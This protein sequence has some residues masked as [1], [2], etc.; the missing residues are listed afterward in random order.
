MAK[1]NNI[2][3]TPTTRN[4]GVEGGGN[5]IITSGSGTWTAAVSD[6]WI[7]LNSTSGSAGYPVAY[8][9]SVNTNAEQRVG[10]VY[11]SGWTHTITQD[12]VGATIS[13]ENNTVEKDRFVG[14]IDVSAANKIVWHANPDVDWIH[15]SPASG[16]G[17]GTVQYMVEPLEDV[18]TRQGTLT[19][20]GNTFTVFQYG[21][22]MK[23][24]S[25]SVTKDYETH[26][27]PITVNA[28]AITQWSVTP[29]N[30]WISVVDAGNGQGGDL[31]T[32]AIAENPSYK[33]RTGTVKIGTET[34][35][36]TQQGRPT[37]ALS[38]SV[39]PTA[40]TASVEG[41]NGL[42]SVTA[43][44][45][46]P[47]TA[48]SGANW[49][50][51][52][53]ATANGAGNGNVV[54]SASPN[55]T[56]S[57][58]TG[59]ITVKPEAASGMA[60]KTHKVTQPAAQSALSMSGYEFVAAGESCSVDVSVAN[61]VQWSISES[62]D[63]ITVN[64]ST[65]RTGPGTVT[66]QA[67]ANNTVYSR[68]GT[69]KIAGK[70]FSV[71]QKARGV[72]LEYDTKIFGTDGGYES[73][74]IH[75]DGNVSWTAV[76]SDPTWI[77]IFQGDS[78]TGD[79]EIMYIVAPYVGDDSSRTGWIEVGD[80]KVYITQRAYEL[81]ISPNGS[82]VKGNNGVGEF[83]VSA[84]IGAVWTA[85]VTEP[86][87]TLVSGYDAGTG[88]G[89][90]RF[91]C[92]DNNTG[93][94]RVGKIVVAGEMYTIT[95]SARILVQIQATAGHGGSLTGSGTYDKGEKIVLKAVPDD[96]YR[97]VRWTG[98][99]ASTANP[100]TMDADELTG[101]RAEFEPLPV[102]FTAAR[103]SL[104]GVD[105]S[106]NTLAWATTYRLYR[107]TS[108]KISAAATL[109]TLPGGTDTYCDGT[110]ERGVSY[111]YWIEA[112]GDA[113]DVV[114]GPTNGMKRLIVNSPITYTNLKGAT[115]SNPDSYVEGREVSFSHPSAV[116]GY[117]FAGW[118]P[119]R[120]TEDMTGAQAVRANWTA[121]RYSI[122]Y[123]ANGGTGTMLPEDATYDI[124][125][126]AAA[127][128]FALEGHSFAGW[129]TN[130]ASAVV[131]FVPG[132]PMTNLTDVAD[133]EFN[134]YAVWHVN[135]YTIAFNA[136]GGTGGKTVTQDYGSALSAPT[137][138]RTG[139]T[140]NGWSP[141]VPTTVPN[142]NVTYT[143]QWKMNQ[144]T[145]KFD[146]NGGEGGWSRSM[147]YGAT[148]T[149]PTVTRTGYT[150][151]GW[152]S[153]V[154]GTVPVGGATYTAQWKMNQY[155]VTFNANGGEG[156][157]ARSL[158]YGAAI[159]APTVTRTGYTFTGWSPT[160]SGTVPVGGATYVAQWKI[161]QYMVTFDA[162]GGEGGWTR[163]MDYGAALSAPVVTRTGYTFAGWSSSVPSTMPAGN[164]T[165]VA[166]W[167]VNQY[168][169]KFDAN[170]GEGGK[171][172]TQN[173]GTALTAPTVTRTGYTFNGWSPSVPATMPAGNATY[174]AQWKVNQYTVKFDA[175]GG[176]GGKTVTQNYGTAL[177]APTVTRTGYTFN[178]WSPSVPATM[179]AGN[180]TYV[181]QWT[182]NQYT[183]TFGA[184]GGEGG[185]TVTQNYGTA[186]SA[187]T[188]TRTGYTFNGWSPSVPA[189][190]PAG[191]ATYVAQWKANQYTVTFDANG[192]EGGWTRSMDY[193]AAISAPA[194]TRT[195]YTFAGWSPS[196]PAT[197]PAGNAIYVAQWTINQYT[198]TFN[199]NG[200]EGGKTVTLNYG[201]ALSAPTVTR[202]GYTFNGWSPYVPST[203]PAGNVTYTAQWTANR[204]TVTFS[205]NGGTGG[206]TV[207]QNY[208][209]ALSAP[210]VTRTGY[211]FNGWSP[212]DP[213]TVSAG[214]VTYTA[215]WAANRYTVTFDA[216]GGKGSMADLPFVYDEPQA[217]AP[218]AFT[219]EEFRFAGWKRVR[220]GEVSYI[221][222]A[223]V[224]N[225]TAQSGGVVT[226]YA[227]WKVWTKAMQ[228]CDE[229]F[230]GAGDVSLDANG[231]I[232]VT[233]TGDVNGTVE[234]PDNVGA[235]TI[236]L[237]GHSI[238]GDGGGLGETALPGGP[239]IR[240]VKGDGEG[241]TTRL[242]IVDTSDGE[243]GQIFGGGESAG[244]EIA[245]DAA[246]GLRL[247]VEEGV[248]VFNG[249]GS[250]QE[251]KP[252]LVGTGKVTVPKTW[253]TGQKVT[254]KAIADK[255]S[256]FARWEG[257]VVDSLN[258]TK[259]ERRNP[260]LAFAVPEGFATN[261][262][263][264][265]FIPIDDD[266]L[267]TLGITQTE[268]EFKE[269]VSDVCVTDDSQS[270]VTASAS[271]LPTGLKFNAKT[272][273]ITGT[274]TKGGVFWVQIK[275]KN[276]SGYQWAENVK[277][278]VSGDGKEAKEPKLTR[279]AYHPFTVICATE[280]GTASGTGVYA[281]GKKV[282]IKATPAKGY[283][284]AGW[285]ETAAEA[286]GGGRGA[287]ALPASM[288]VTLPGADYRSPSMSVAVPEMRYVFARFATKEEDAAS[289]ALAVEDATTEK[290]GTIGTPG[291]DGTRALNLGACVSSLSL[292]KLMVTGLPAGLKYNAKALKVS[293]K[294]TKPGV[295]TVT[296]KATNASVTRATDVTTA[297]FKITV[298]NFECAALPGL[299]PETDAYGTIH[300]GVR[301]GP[302]LIDCTPEDGWTVKAAGLPAGLKFAAKETKDAT[303]GVVPA[304]TIYGVPTAKAGAYTV[305]FT[306]SKKG[307][308]NQIATI[309]LN[310][311]A[312]PAWAV[313]T[314]TGAVFD[315]SDAVV[316][317]VQNITVSS[318]GKISGKII[319]GDMTW[320]L[321]AP[322]FDE[323]ASLK[324]EVGSPAFTATAIAR[325]GKEVAT[326]AVTVAAEA[327]IGVASGGLGTVP[328]GTEAGP[329]AWT[330]WRNVWK[331][332][333]RKEE[334][335]T[336]KNLKIGPA[337]GGTVTF[338]APTA[339]GA[340]TAKLKDGGYSASCSTTLIP[341]DSGYTLFWYFP[342]KAGKFAGD[343]G[344]E[345]V[346]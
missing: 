277:V 336:L 9:V 244:V 309:T 31:V 53:A 284:F 313:G 267:Y 282:T 173:Y 237:N 302:G 263:T 48:T 215:Q 171:T 328:V 242:A 226:L 167:K 87:I 145:V 202:T 99:V 144:Y 21:R 273:Q 323:A 54:Y 286:K 229:R 147:D 297:T 60:A 209:T 305:T 164:V 319:D 71:S 310:V 304:W 89:T 83:G 47:W 131:S 1:N 183:A 15:V 246:T 199:A 316:G 252:K 219:A 250:E 266:G 220:D 139:Y 133:G 329:P 66:L 285:Y 138:T 32:I 76:A 320:T 14:T 330:A 115:H 67:A 55:P 228:D 163:S 96:G 75:P 259:N 214:N 240:I 333:D 166:Q 90:V 189:T 62:L 36:V 102:E 180:A 288:S 249:D 193:G 17:S 340:V 254:W 18:S 174:V 95:Q 243:K 113:D 159:S 223:V 179:P 126:A 35:T 212:S 343:G 7:V 20:A 160:V 65:S 100:L 268:F 40:S 307:E 262:V 230:G 216:N 46:L 63:W 93:K 245:E 22:R 213:S 204:Y 296:V 272:L 52:Y 105:L 56:L 116:A 195:G 203:V 161:N 8:T 74:A 5:A 97:F 45:D 298:P 253:K 289:L 186:L 279:T 77:T 85:I 16:T 153:S 322:S 345:E 221:D 274:P 42:I 292:P 68:S 143:A 148:I 247:D 344:C 260:S 191:N 94:P 327:G 241:E 269:A 201:T 140:F 283:V 178:G 120:I 6:P 37:A 278:T 103:S 118:T 299:K 112:A 314:F 338:S 107:G 346:K 124:E 41:A 86:W 44:P 303:Y 49:L 58:R 175:N 128:G 335:K 184:N 108:N 181:A 154:A 123:N 261:M 332:A 156:G 11:V 190:M 211:T 325:A 106:W 238:V 10:Y 121:N 26:V 265:V 157:W 136:N 158:D 142:G 169:V 24:D 341:T 19:V 291:T 43:T 339:A 151:T 155:K 69:V 196:V 64:G 207:T 109:A 38:F 218:A 79:G 130:A 135:S 146:A 270:Y 301:F 217:L 281:E 172:V 311:E 290:D 59:T 295:Y 150:F 256:A 34:F 236:D 132:Q 117:A 315:E 182:I 308:K 208:G 39:S 92:A 200:G 275:A 3:I 248:G 187:P 255:G 342:P 331:D 233:L 239:A 137:V 149:A 4:F 51:I 231:N 210:T 141:S 82:A 205:A 271:G 78:G 50:T 2:S 91:I 29:N 258:L 81:S 25:Y 122:I 280:G 312:L 257:P 162:N 119:E 287:T 234:I 321:S 129:A 334:A 337:R 57:Q 72:E 33:K 293:G 306:A 194:V 23:L 30:S 318:A 80:K 110:G 197:M 101:I 264:A 206:K 224:S 111:W 276:A 152:S 98:P 84:S 88:S 300:A 28:L 168:M 165:Y 177:S 127:N 134:L 125:V 114:S 61:I 225:L 176:E 104:D 251:L 170:G 12:G 227:A 13:P 324:S 235:V 185:K 326:N 198:A 73:V 27:I 294:A 222:Q 232:V 192:G 70:T 188:V 317:Q